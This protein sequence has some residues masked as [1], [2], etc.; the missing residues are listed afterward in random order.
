[1]SKYD[2]KIAD[3]TKGQ[4]ANGC[5]WEQL[6]ESEKREKILKQE[7]RFAQDTIAQ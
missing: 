5:L 2:K 3:L 4:T 1:M 7:L 6:A